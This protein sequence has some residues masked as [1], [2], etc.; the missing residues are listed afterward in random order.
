VQPY[1]VSQVGERTEFR[2]TPTFAAL[3]IG[4]F[5]FGAYLC[6]AIGLWLVLT[7]WPEVAGL[8]VG[9]A[10]L[11]AALLGTVL[12]LWAWRT[13]NLALTIEQH[14]AVT[15]GSRQLCTSAAVKHILIAPA[16]GEGDCDVTLELHDGSQVAIPSQYFAGL[17]SKD[18]ASDFAEHLATALAVPVRRV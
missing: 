12:A 11:A 5:A 2:P 7:A 6:A 15:Y 17:T 8:V 3:M 14:G 4:M 16:R 9:F 18:L 10:F 13:R 1:A